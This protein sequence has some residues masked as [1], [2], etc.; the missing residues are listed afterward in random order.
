MWIRSM[1][2]FLVPRLSCLCQTSFYFIWKEKDRNQDIGGEPANTGMI[3]L[4][5]SAFVSLDTK[6]QTSAA[7]DTWVCVAPQTRALQ[8]QSLTGTAAA[9]QLNVWTDKAIDV[10]EK[11]H[12]PKQEMTDTSMNATHQEVL[13]EHRLTGRKCESDCKPSDGLS[14]TR[15]P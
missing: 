15:K 9:T 10:M 8:R 1:L 11:T 7:S 3:G 4:K 13:Q 6:C 5:G 2:F 12:S 14:K